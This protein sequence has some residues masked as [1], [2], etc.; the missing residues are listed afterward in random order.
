MKR[1]I[2]FLLSST[3]VF[4][5]SIIVSANP[6]FPTGND[7]IVLSSTSDD[8]FIGILTASV[9]KWNLCNGRGEAKIYTADG[10]TAEAYFR[11]NVLD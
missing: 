6:D 11:Y 9:L 8:E 1:F 5:S 4:N 10:S 7:N 2:S 3:I